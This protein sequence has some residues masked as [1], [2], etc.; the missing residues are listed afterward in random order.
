MRTHSEI[1]RLIESSGWGTEDLRRRVITKYFSSKSSDINILQKDYGFGEKR[2]LDI[3]CSYGQSLLYWGLDSV[4]IDVSEEMASLPKALGYEIFLTNVEDRLCPDELIGCFEGVFSDNM[5][6]HLVSPHLFLIRINKLL[7]PGGLIALGHPTVP[8]TAF[9]KYLWKRFYGY[10]GYLAAEHINFYTPET[11]AL[12]LKRAGL[13]VIEQ[14]HPLP[15]KL[16]RLRKLVGPFSTHCYTVARK[17]GDWHYSTKRR[18]DF[19]PTFFENEL[20][21]FH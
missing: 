16:D 10:E 17:I 4:G 13:D 7:K 8:L 12:A 1:L 21:V 15:R 9:A 18:A 19:D 2:I 3:G 11:I 5:I 6:E 20:Q 14:W